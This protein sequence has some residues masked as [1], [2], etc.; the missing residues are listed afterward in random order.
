[1]LHDICATELR[2][3]NSHGNHCICGVVAT[4][5]RYGWH[6]AV[7]PDWWSPTGLSL[8]LATLSRYYPSS[9]L[10]M[11]AMKG[12]SRDAAKALE[13]AGHIATEAMSAVRTVQAF[14]LQVIF[15]CIRTVYS[16]I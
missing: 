11:A 9:L 4:G 5:P 15:R 14:N 7:Y 8:A 1:M 12:F 16:N 3:S 13:E 2:N 6:S 10:Q